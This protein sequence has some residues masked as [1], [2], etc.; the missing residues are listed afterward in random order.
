M[1]GDDAR[2]IVR[3]VLRE[4]APDADLDRV[5]PD[6][7]LEESLGLDSLDFI[8]FVAGLHEL[9]GIE[10]PERDYPHLLTIEGC[11]TYLTSRP[12]CCT[13]EEPLSEK[14]QR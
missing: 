7:T 12:G 13:V 10:V 11:V 3:K 2:E 1:T 9:A 6:Q 8:R 5:S 14:G 4:V